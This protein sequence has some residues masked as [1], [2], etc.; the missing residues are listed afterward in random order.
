M[1]LHLKIFPRKKILTSFNSSKARDWLGCS[2]HFVKNIVKNCLGS[3]T[4]YLDM[5]LVTKSFEENLR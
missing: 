4:K 1:N 5:Y 3:G 2:N